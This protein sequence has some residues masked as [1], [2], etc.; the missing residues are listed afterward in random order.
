MTIDSISSRYALIFGEL[1][2]HSQSVLADLSSYA[3][4]LEVLEDAVPFIPLD[5]NTLRSPFVAIF[6]ARS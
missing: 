2:A 6:F 1:I 5:N 3:S 4:L